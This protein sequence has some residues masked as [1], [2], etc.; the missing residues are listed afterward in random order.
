M[1]GRGLYVPSCVA[2]RVDKCAHSLTNYNFSQGLE[3]TKVIRRIL[4]DISF[5]SNIVFPSNNSEFKTSY[6][7]SYEKR[8]W[9]TTLWCPTLWYP[10]MPHIL[11]IADL[12]ICRIVPKILILEIVTTL[13]VRIVRTVPLITVESSLEINKILITARVSQLAWGWK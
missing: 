3:I 6:E 10:M 5:P 4:Y 1:L 11:Q 2:S 12:Y 8:F 13:A 9:L 7:L